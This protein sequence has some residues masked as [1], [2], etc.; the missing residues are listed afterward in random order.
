MI[1]GIDDIPIIEKIG[2]AYDLH[3][4]ILEDIVT[5][6]QRP[7]FDNYEKYA[8]IVLKM[9]TYFRRKKWL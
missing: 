3:P 5:A 2:K 8:Y 6:G 9:L 7:K 4:L 1:D